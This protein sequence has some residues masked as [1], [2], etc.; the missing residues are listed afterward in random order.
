MLRL[1]LAAAA[2]LAM[3][4]STVAQAAPITIVAV[5]AS[6]TSGFYI[7]T[8][9]AYPAQ[10]EAMLRAKGVNARVINA[11]RP[12]DVTAGML[13][14]I[15]QAV[16]DGT[17]IA[18]L[19]PGGNDQRFFV[20]HEQ[21]AANIAAMVN[22]LHARHIQTIVFDPVIP[23]QYYAWDRIH[24]TV[25]GHTWIASSLLPQVLAIVRKP[26][27]TAQSEPH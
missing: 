20:S 10:L 18:V 27:A 25:E 19:Q 12:F 5:G 14:R 8:E 16:P 6:N 4:A 7:A 24:L 3:L 2:L 21:R 17:N 13:A 23:S 15:D 11:G 1:G 9:Q 26:Q 22:R